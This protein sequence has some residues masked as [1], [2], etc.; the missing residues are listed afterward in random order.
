MSRKLLFAATLIVLSVPFARAQVNDIAKA[1]PESAGYGFNLTPFY[2]RPMTA[3]DMRDME[4]DRKYRET[5]A[6]IPNKKPPRDPWA[7]VRPA[8]AEDRHRPQ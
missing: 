3:Q 1:L 4:I 5:L 2:E 7:G 8:T 6:K